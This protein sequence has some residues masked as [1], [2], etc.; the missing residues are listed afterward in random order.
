MREMKAAPALTKKQL[1]AL[2]AL[3]YGE[4]FFVKTL[5]PGAAHKKWCMLVPG[6]PTPLDI[7]GRIS[8]LCQKRMCR[9]MAVDKGMDR[10]SMP[11]LLTARGLQELEKYPDEE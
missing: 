5:V 10:F 6:R 9:Y 8:K 3:H 7:T 4:V 11:L 2:R 1:E